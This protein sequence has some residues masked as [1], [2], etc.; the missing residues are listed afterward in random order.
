MSCRLI[1]QG[2]PACGP[3]DDYT[4]AELEPVVL[5]AFYD[6]YIFPLLK[7]HQ[8]VGVVPGTY[9]NNSQSVTEQDPWVTKKFAGYWSW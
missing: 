7:P 6:R 5:K 8:T 3:S 9:G 2:V 1:L 4:K